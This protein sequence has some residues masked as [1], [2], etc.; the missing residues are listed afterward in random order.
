MELDS[1][2][3]RNFVQMLVEQIERENSE[4]EKAKRR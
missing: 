3:R 4:I 1:F 2:E